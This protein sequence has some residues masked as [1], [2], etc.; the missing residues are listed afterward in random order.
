MALTSIPRGAVERATYTFGFR[1]RCFNEAF[2]IQTLGF[3][4]VVNSCN[5]FFLPHM[6]PCTLGIG[7]P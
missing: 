4:K 5:I 7:F 1:L 3:R 6:H 2:P